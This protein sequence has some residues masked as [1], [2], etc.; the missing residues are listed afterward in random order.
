MGVKGGNERTNIGMIRG[1][2]QDSLGIL[3]PPVPNSTKVLI[4]KDL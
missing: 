2:Y 1:V 4:H 3:F